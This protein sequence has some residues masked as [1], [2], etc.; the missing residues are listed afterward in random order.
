MVVGADPP[1]QLPRRRV[2]L[3]E[4]ILDGVQTNSQLLSVDQ[5]VVA[6]VFAQSR[7]RDL[8]PSVGVKHAR[9]QV[10]RVPY[11]NFDPCN[12]RLPQL[13]DD[14]SRDFTTGHRVG[15]TSRN[16]SEW[17]HRGRAKGLL[18]M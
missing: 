11:R 3:G 15:R 2:Y 10:F 1:E 5:A 14:V 4:V 18:P 13:A 8:L 9:P 7:L 6:A 17:L 12:A 16:S